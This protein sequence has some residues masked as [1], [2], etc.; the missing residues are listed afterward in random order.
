MQLYA[1]AGLLG[2]SV[3]LMWC[4]RGFFLVYSFLAVAVATAAPHCPV[5]VVSMRW[6]ASDGPRSQND[7]MCLALGAPWWHW[8]EAKADKF[9]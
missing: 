3:R 8:L 1:D 9:N 2:K 5:V 6:C 4:A 7:T